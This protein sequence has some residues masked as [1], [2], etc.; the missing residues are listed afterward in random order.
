MALALEDLTLRYWYT[1]EPNAPNQLFWCDYAEIDCSH[2]KGTFV[3]EARMGATHYLQVSFTSGSLA[4]HADTGEIQT[5]FNKE[6]WSIFDEND[7][8]SFDSSKTAFA[9]WH[10][11]TLYLDGMLI[12]GQEPAP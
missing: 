8:Y 1:L 2:V 12:W 9:D 11:V 3:A 10:K 5:R 4:A 6:D 7:D